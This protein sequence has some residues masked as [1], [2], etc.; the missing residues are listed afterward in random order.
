MAK[1]L[2]KATGIREITPGVFELIVQTGRDPVTGKYR[3]T[4]HRFRGTL[5]EAKAARAELV[6]EVKRGRHVGTTATMDELCAAWL[7]ELERKDRSPRT[8]DE[9][10]RRY[11][12]DIQ[13]TLGS[14]RV[15]KVTTKMLT[16]LY[17]EHQRRGIAPASVHK[18][19]ATLSSMMSQAC[20]WGWRSSNP[21]EWAEPPPIVREVPI[22]PTPAEVL[23][24]IEEARRSRRP[25]QA[26]VIYFAATTGAR[27]G[28]ICALRR[29]RVDW[30]AGTVLIDRA[31]VKQAGRK[32]ER[33]TKNRRSRLVAVDERVMRFLQVQFDEARERASVV[34]TELVSDPYVLSCSVEGD[35]PWDPDTITQYFARLR[36]RLDLGHVEFKGLRRFMDTY[37]QE[38]GFS[39]AQVAM[40]AGHDPVVAG[41]HYTGRVSQA[42]RDLAAAIGG[43]LRGLPSERQAG[44]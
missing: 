31:I 21:A 36:D 43:L 33:P 44:G 42:D 20:R 9:Y 28:E 12:H 32:V 23:L 16:D 4:F 18:I 24:L 10:R 30:G 34:G 8:V 13:P 29:S 19:H 39:M 2:R 37:G 3:Q 1:P 7:Q 22:V 14:V 27:R 6:A 17:G 25:E 38:L 26:E 35:E 40:R 11:R 41:R 15:T 5:Q